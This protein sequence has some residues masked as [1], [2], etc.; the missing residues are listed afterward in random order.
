ME[1]AARG[2]AIY[3]GSGV[4]RRAVAGRHASCAGESSQAAGVV[5]S[6]TSE[7]EHSDGCGR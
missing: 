5:A 4:P 1:R 3:S 2:D 7:L 6:T